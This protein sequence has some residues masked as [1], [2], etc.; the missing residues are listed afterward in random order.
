M[1]SA[2]V[3][4]T[5]RAQRN[6]SPIGEDYDRAVG[7]LR[8]RVYSEGNGPLHQHRVVNESPE[9]EGSD[10][11]E[12]FVEG[13]DHSQVKTTIATKYFFTWADIIGRKARSNRHEISSN[14]WLT[15]S[16]ASLHCRWT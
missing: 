6:L 1:R 9:P 12:F 11:D 4:T 10:V 2:S 14:E 3:L 16:P 15:D 8:D 5:G 7:R 13:S